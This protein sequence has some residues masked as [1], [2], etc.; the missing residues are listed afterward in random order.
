[1]PRGAC[2]LPACA[3]HAYHLVQGHLPPCDPHPP[4]RSRTQHQHQ[5]QHGQ[6]AGRGLH[7][8]SGTS[9]APASRPAPSNPVQGVLGCCL[10]QHGLQQLQGAL[11]LIMMNRQRH[12]QLAADA[13]GAPSL[14]ARQQQPPRPRQLLLLPP[15]LPAGIAAELQHQWPPPLQPGERWGGA[16]GCRPALPLVRQAAL[17]PAEPMLLLQGAPWLDTSQV[18]VRRARCCLHAH[19]ACTSQARWTDSCPVH[20][21]CCCPPARPPTAAGAT[22]HLASLAAGAALRLGPRRSGLPA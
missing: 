20:C 7:A 19:P 6:L 3:Q 1:M 13:T 5:H 11:D 18:L 12:W 16:R 10:A 8:I 17:L 14:L 15:P 22:G 2:R 4:P 9:A 21:C